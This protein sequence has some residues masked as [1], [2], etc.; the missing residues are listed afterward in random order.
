MGVA[1]RSHVYTMSSL[2][3]DLEVEKEYNI[4]L[5]SFFP[6]FEDMEASPGFFTS[7]DEISYNNEEEEDEG[8]NELPKTPSCPGMQAA[9][10]LVLGRSSATTTTASRP[11]S[12]TSH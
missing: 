3:W 10:P 5:H 11:P 7:G 4:R 8:D 2:Y 9:I 12:C 6:T 1:V